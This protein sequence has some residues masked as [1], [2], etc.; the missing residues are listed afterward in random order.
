MRRK[1]ND[2]TVELRKA[3]RDEQITKHRNIVPLND[4]EELKF[5]PDHEMT[6]ENIKEGKN[7]ND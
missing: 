6:L 7:H 1:R 4:D 5:N 3:L 2:V